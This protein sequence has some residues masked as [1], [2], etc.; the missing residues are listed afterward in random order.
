MDKKKPT[1]NE[2]KAEARRYLRLLKKSGFNIRAAYIFG[3]FVRGTQRSD[4]DIDLLISVHGFR[5]WMEATSKLQ[6]LRFDFDEKIPL[7]VIGHSKPRLDLG[8]PLEREVAKKG[9]RLV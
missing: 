8:I 2:A 9:I 3:S 7:D 1:L 4:S 6:R 5:D